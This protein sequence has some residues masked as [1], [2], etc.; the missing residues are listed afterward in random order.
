[1]A[2]NKG[3][4]GSR[5]WFISDRSGF[6]FPYRE[7]IKES[8]TGRRIHKSES[9]GAYNLVDHPLNH[10]QRYAR[11]GDPFPVEDPRGHGEGV[12]DDITGLVTHL[13]AFVLNEYSPV[14]NN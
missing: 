10:V 8:G 1:M 9:D 12:A 14:T 3:K 6:R 2:G 7:S 5:A 11:H 4:G 13:G